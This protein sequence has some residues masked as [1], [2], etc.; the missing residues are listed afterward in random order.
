M[1]L[2]TS[3]TTTSFVRSPTNNAFLELSTVGNA[4]IT[5]NFDIQATCAQF[6]IND[7]T[8]P[9]SIGI[10]GQ[11]LTVSGLT[12]SAWQYCPGVYSQTAPTIGVTDTAAE[13]N[14]INGTGLG[15]ADISGL[16]QGDVLELSASGTFRNRNGAQTI[17]WRLYSGA[18]LIWDTGIF[19]MASVNSFRPWKVVLSICLSTNLIVNGGFSYRSAT[20]TLSGFEIE[21]I[22]AFSGGPL[23]LTVQW[24]AANLQNS[25][26]CNRVTLSRLF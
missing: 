26:A 25:L 15:S 3:S 8:L 24:G 4:L 16:I 20:T 22:T 6:Q 9:A 1:V 21:T 5:T 18:T 12:S 10:G 17:Q 11:V 14:L 2:L 13:V 7:Y 19:T 23:Q